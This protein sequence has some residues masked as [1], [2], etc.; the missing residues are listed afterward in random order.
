MRFHQSTREQHSHFDKTCATLYVLPIYGSACGYSPTSKGSSCAPVA[1]AIQSTVMY[2]FQN[3]GCYVD[4]E[5]F[6]LEGETDVGRLLFSRRFPALLQTLI[7]GCATQLRMNRPARTSRRANCR[8]HLMWNTMGAR[9]RLLPLHNSP[10]RQVSKSN[11]VRGE[12]NLSR[13]F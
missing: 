2:E 11:L 13:H 12:R 6:F 3:L 10:T 7:P 5:F 8:S 4:A 1:Y 9:P